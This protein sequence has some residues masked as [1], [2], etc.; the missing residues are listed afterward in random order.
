[1]EP[2]SASR[3]CLSRG[4]IERFPHLVDAP[5]DSRSSLPLGPIPD[6]S[7]VLFSNHTIH[8]ERPQNDGENAHEPPAVDSR[9]AAV[10]QTPTSGGDGGAGESTTTKRKS[11]PFRR[12]AR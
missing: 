3:L 2:H 6:E 4:L 11:K 7:P 5:I 9:S 8:E 12:V 10:G 1:M